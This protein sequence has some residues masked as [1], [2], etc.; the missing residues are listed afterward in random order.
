MSNNELLHLIDK[1]YCTD[2]E[3]AISLSN[4]RNGYVAWCD[5]SSLRLTVDGEGESP[6]GWRTVDD[7]TTLSEFKILW[8]DGAVCKRCGSSDGVTTKF[9]RVDID[10]LDIRAELTCSTGH[11]KHCESIFVRS[12]AVFGDFWPA[13]EEVDDA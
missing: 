9:S 8:E 1:L 5:C 4:D 3:L 2:C 10:E 11:P 6:H 13:L 12:N 7:L